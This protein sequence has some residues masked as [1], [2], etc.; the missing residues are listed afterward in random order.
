[1]RRLSAAIGRPVTFALL[2]V[3]SAPDLWRQLLDIS[4][5]AVADGADL[6]PQVGARATGLLA[7][8]LHHTLP[9]RKASRLPG[10]EGQKPDRTRNWSP[11]CAIP[12]CV[13]RS[14]RGNPNTTA[15]A[16]MEDAYRNTSYL[17][18][19]PDYEPGPNAP[20]L[21]TS[22]PTTGRRPLEVAYD[23]MLEGEGT[24]AFS[25]SPS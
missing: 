7:G 12:P 19:P 24:G 17:G 10:P 15:A 23:A 22:P 13:T 8:Q 11:L 16:R 5:E 25:T 18:T 9:V 4:L 21:T 3:A 2:Q 14:C 20:S 1:M 6:W